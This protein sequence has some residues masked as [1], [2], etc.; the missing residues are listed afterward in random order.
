M[1]EIE[2][3]KNWNVSKNTQKYY[4]VAVNLQG[5]CVVRRT[6]RRMT[7][8]IHHHHPLSGNNIRAP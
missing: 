1:K 3:T 6:P 8:A 2:Y 4:S 7:T 5:H